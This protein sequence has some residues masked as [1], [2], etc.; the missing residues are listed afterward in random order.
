M[1]IEA[2]G[3]VLTSEVPA[4]GDR[5]AFTMRKQRAL[6]F[7]D[8]DEYPIRF[9]LTLG[10][11][12]ALNPGVRYRFSSDSFVTN[13]FGALRFAFEHGLVP[14]KTAQPVKASA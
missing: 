1:H 14:A 13:E 2:K 11:G 9:T 12:P 8:D 6:L 10:D 3:D 7:L 5:A 4:K